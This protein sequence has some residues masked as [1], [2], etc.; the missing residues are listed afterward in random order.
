ME[1]GPYTRYD[2]KDPDNPDKKSVLD[3]IIVSASLVKYIDKLVIDTDHRFTPS[4]SVKGSL[5]YPDHYALMLMIKQI[6]MKKTQIIPP[7][8]EIVWNTRKKD[9]WEKY[10]QKTE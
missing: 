7:R 9:D 5:K 6:P 2:P 10:L 4:R 3:Y 8:K 1:N